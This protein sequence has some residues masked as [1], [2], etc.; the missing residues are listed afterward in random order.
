MCRWGGGDGIE[1]F[2]VVVGLGLSDV[3]IKV[4][5]VAVWSVCL[6]VGCGLGNCFS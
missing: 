2:W 4:Q 3:A 5:T 1:G 6:A